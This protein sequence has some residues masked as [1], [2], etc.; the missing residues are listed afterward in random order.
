MSKD[1]KG[2]PHS[3]GAQRRNPPS[4]TGAG[5]FERRPRQSSVR[6]QDRQRTCYRP[7]SLP[8]GGGAMRGIGEKFSTNPSTGTGL[9][10]VPIATSPGRVEGDAE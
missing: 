2:A 10:S 3:R 9:L 5:A 6:R 4:G 7:S 8:K 1:E